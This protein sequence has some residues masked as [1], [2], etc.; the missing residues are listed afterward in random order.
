MCVYYKRNLYWSCAVTSAELCYHALIV[1]LQS[2]KY[3]LQEEYPD[4]LKTLYEHIRGFRISVPRIMQHG[5]L[6]FSRLCGR[7]QKDWTKYETLVQ[8]IDGK[9]CKAQLRCKGMVKHLNGH[10]SNGRYHK[11]G[12][13]SIH[14]ESSQEQQVR[15]L[16]NGYVSTVA[17]QSSHIEFYSKQKIIHIS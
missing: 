2:A 1:S 4:K 14:L 5:E 9:R 13:P 12:R 11:Q 16:V 17:I 8:L 10:F 15:C 7:P 6:Y 3:L